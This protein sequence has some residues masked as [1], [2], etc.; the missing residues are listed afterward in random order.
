MNMELRY[1]ESVTLEPLQ[2]TW[3]GLD[4]VYLLSGYELVQTE[5]GI[6]TIIHDIDGLHRAI[7]E[8]LVEHKKALNGKDVRF[9]RKQMNL[10]QND[11]GRLM[12]TSDQ[13]VARWEKGEYPIPGPEE[14]LLRVVYAADTKGHVNVR[15][16][17]EELRALDAPPKEKMV[18]TDTPM[19]WKAAA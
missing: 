12:S 6:D 10:T 13:T 7:G 4:D 5:D 14:T 16:F 9:L 17:I 1:G 3:C 8:C 18:F 19:G 15:E 2:Y 11:L